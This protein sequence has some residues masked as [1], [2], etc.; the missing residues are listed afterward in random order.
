MNANLTPTL[1]RT[2]RVLANSKRLALMR[3]VIEPGG[4]TVSK[5]AEETGYPLAEVSLMLRQL[6]SRGLVRAQRKG[7][8]VIY[9]GEADPKIAHA[10]TLLKA[11]AHALGR[12][13]KPDDIVLSLTAFTH[14]RRIMLVRAMEEGGNSVER[15]QELCR[16]SA[17]ACYRH[18][19]KLIHRGFVEKQA[20]RTYRLVRPQDP[21]AQTLLRLARKDRN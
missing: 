13:V 15:L 18:L 17:P 6:Q 5:A 12:N 10:S 20:D 2:C 4:I 1:W 7:R 21:L 3:C 11:V 19:S 16:M 9:H 8:W 14:A